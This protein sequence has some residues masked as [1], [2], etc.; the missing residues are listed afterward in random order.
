MLEIDVLRAKGTSRL[1]LD[2]FDNAFAVVQMLT[3]EHSDNI[4]DDDAIYTDATRWCIIRH[5]GFDNLSSLY[6][7][8]H[9]NISPLVLISSA[10]GF[11]IGC[12]PPSE[13]AITTHQAAAPSKTKQNHEHGVPSRNEGP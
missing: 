7:R 13:V 10:F 12:A 11:S 1:V 2:P 3:I 8:S 4:T 5:I 9:F 6:A